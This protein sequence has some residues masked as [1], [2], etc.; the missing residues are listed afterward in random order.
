MLG[1]RGNLMDKKFIRKEF[2]DENGK[3][4]SRYYKTFRFDTDEKRDLWLKRLKEF[5]LPES[6]YIEVNSKDTNWKDSHSIV[7]RAT[8]EEFKFIEELIFIKYAAR[9]KV[10]EKDKR[11]KYSK[12]T[13]TIG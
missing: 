10:I 11:R 1:K 5:K 4:I 8:K 6:V 12:R 7:I 9:F 3:H 13:E 2:L